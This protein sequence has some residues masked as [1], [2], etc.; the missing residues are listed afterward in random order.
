MVL[1]SLTTDS[2]AYFMA[3]MAIL[4]SPCGSRKSPRAGVCP[5]VEASGGALSYL[6]QVRSLYETASNP[7]ALTALLSFFL[8]RSNELLSL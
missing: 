2:Y 3:R 1:S 4:V 6:L 5:I 8:L 7:G